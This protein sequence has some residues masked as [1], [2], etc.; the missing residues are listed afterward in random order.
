MIRRPPRSTLFPYTTLFRSLCRRF[1]ISL[2][3]IDRLLRGGTSD[4]RLGVYAFFLSHEDAKER[5]QYL[6]SCHGEYSGSHGGNDNMEYTS[7]GVS[8]SHGSIT[9][10]YA[11]L[12][13]SW[14]KA[15][16]R[17]A[18]LIESGSFLSEEDRA[19]M[20]DYERRVLAERSEERRVGKE[21]RSRWSPYH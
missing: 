13:W 10:P 7:K 9:A 14:N 5:E 3:E 17:I 6:R 2:D 4:Y 21:C 19:A 15:S 12:D 16:R 11:K 8:F 20:P 1:F 18:S